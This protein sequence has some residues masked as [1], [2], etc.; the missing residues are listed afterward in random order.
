MQKKKRIHA[1]KERNGLEIFEQSNKEGK[2]FMGNRMVCFQAMA[3]RSGEGI[4][5]WG[6]CPEN[7]KPAEKPVKI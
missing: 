7:K 2:I 1:K 6:K 5:N 4:W 3:R